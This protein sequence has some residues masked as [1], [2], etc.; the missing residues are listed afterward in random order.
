MG[1]LL[2]KP[3][4]SKHAEDGSGPSGKLA[5]GVSA[6]Q[7]WRR[8]MEDAHLAMPEF[9]SDRRLAL[10]GVFDGH[11]GAAV[12]KIAAEHF[13]S[14]LRSLPS[15]QEGRYADALKEAYLQLD[16]FLDSTSGRKQVAE[17]AA[18]CPDA[19]DG[20]DGDEDIPPEVLRELI[21]SGDVDLDELEKEAANLKDEEAA[22]DEG[23]EEEDMDLLEEEEEEDEQVDGNNAW[24]SGEGPDGMGTT[25]VVALVCC[26][27]S[28]E[29]IV[30]N[31]GD[32][33]CVLARGPRALPLSRDHKP[34]LKCERR[35]IAKAGGFV[36][37]D[38]RVDGNLNLSRALGDFAYKK[39]TSLKAEEQKISCEAEV[40]RRELISTDRYLVL[41][42]DGIFEKATNQ[43][44][45]DFLLP[46]LR[47]RK[48][49]RSRPA[50]LSGVCSAF[51]DA[52]IA[53]N[54]AKEQG[55]GCDNMTLM[56]VDL[57][58]GI[59]SGS[60][61][62]AGAGV[63]IGAE[64]TTKRASEGGRKLK[65]GFKVRRSIRK[66]GFRATLSPQRRRLRL[67]ASQRNALAEP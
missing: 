29:V 44:L 36:S 53:T 57:L 2:P 62:E 37:P 41:G 13:P 60:T 3:E 4:T 12:A 42:C 28:P 38:G 35:R 23:E 47:R 52:N 43:A 14:T 31:A 20:E 27:D 5:F 39:N 17:R 40:R 6:M 58:S 22:E 1:G 30:A 56:I 26:G 65:V 9:D 24:A 63:A 67:L 21:S 50:C 51:L 25:A 54:P 32:S 34:T 15:F 16:Q 59:S 61:A 11:G 66:V 33:R 19:S 45:V 46:R 48:K 10:F 8:G 18:A 64:K 7:G 55:L 49:I